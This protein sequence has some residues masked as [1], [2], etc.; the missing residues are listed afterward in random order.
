WLR[1]A[2][3][4]RTKAIWVAMG[5]PHLRAESRAWSYHLGCSRKIAQRSSCARGG[6]GASTAQPLAS[7]H[8]AAISSGRQWQRDRV[9]GAGGAV[10]RVGITGAPVSDFP[11]PGQ[12]RALRGGHCRPPG[13]RGKGPGRR[14]SAAGEA[15]NLPRGEGSVMPLRQRRIEGDVADGLPVQSHN[16][17][18]EGAEHPLD[19]VILALVDGEQRAVGA[20]QVEA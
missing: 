5:V 10:C 4:W 6:E 13:L 14:G 12:R 2:D 16:P 3:S 9:S 8:Q 7:R 11:A 1:K 15:R 20:E 18:A 19:L 17:V